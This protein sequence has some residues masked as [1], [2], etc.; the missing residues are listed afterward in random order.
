MKRYGDVPEVG[1]KIVI[2]ETKR[3]LTPYTKATI[4]S[5]LNRASRK[6][7]LYPHSSA[8]AVADTLRWIL[9][10]GDCPI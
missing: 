9:G 10:D 5:V 8:V 1:P 6:S 3:F 7:D 2:R 4:E